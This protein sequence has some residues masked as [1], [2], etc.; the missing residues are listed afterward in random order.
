[1]RCSLRYSDLAFDSMLV[2]ALPLVGAQVRT[3]LVVAYS[4]HVTSHSTIKGHL[5][6]LVLLDSIKAILAYYLGYSE[7][8]TP[9]PKRVP[10]LEGGQSIT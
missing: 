6:C 3:V 4:D 1:M 8:T 9:R 10:R 5:F 7:P 2:L